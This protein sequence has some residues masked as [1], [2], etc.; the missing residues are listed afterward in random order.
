MQKNLESRNSGSMHRSEQAQCASEQRARTVRAANAPQRRPSV[1]NWS[2]VCVISQECHV[3]F[4]LTL[5]SLVARGR[6][7]LLETKPGGQIHARAKHKRQL[8]LHIVLRQIFWAQMQ[9][10]APIKN[11]QASR[12]CLASVLGERHARIY[13][14][15]HVGAMSWRMWHSMIKGATTTK[16]RKQ[17]PGR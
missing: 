1:H 13:C 10:G 9:S 12:G 15:R 17:G 6:L 2:H 14:Q 3:F 5:S 4:K 8:D 7:G 11:A 16:N